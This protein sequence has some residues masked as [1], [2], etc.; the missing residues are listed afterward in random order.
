MLKLLKFVPVIFVFSSMAFASS[1]NTLDS[2]L[3][4]NI[5][6]D[7]YKKKSYHVV[8][9]KKSDRFPYAFH[10]STIQMKLIVELFHNRNNNKKAAR[11]VTLGNGYIP[12]KPGIQ[13]TYDSPLVDRF[14][15][16]YPTSFE[17]NIYQAGGVPIFNEDFSPQNET[18]DASVSSTT[19]APTI[20][21]SFTASEKPS[22]A[23]S[24]SSQLGVVYTN[25]YSSKDYVT[26]VTSDGSLDRGTGVKWTTSLSQI[27]T[28]DYQ[29]YKKW[30]GVYHYDSCYNDNLIPEENFP[31]IIY[32]FTPK[33]QYVF[34]P[35]F[36]RS[37]ETKTTT[38]VAKAGMKQ[39]EEGFTRSACT[40]T[41][42]S[43]ESSYLEAQVRF[44]IDWDKLTV[45]QS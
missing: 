24:L 13:H 14:T 28:N 7:G 30:A 26:A 45:T 38:M 10:G 22:G 3:V 25:R 21:L 31:R 15:Q 35:S 4:D 37:S 32:G 33:F 20:G 18:N 27:Y 39:V 11:I 43:S 12:G 23:A 44:T 34:S 17:Y 5:E 42:Y 29:Y 8:L 1:D 36:E 2:I 6:V 19:V 16:N 9:Q 41:D 40:W